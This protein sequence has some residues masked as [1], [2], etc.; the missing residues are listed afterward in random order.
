MTSSEARRT[1]ACIF[2]GALHLKLVAG[3]EIWTT[4]ILS[5]KKKDL[6]ISYMYIQ[7]ADFYEQT[8]ETIVFLHLF[9]IS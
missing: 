7:T 5:G 9:V 3:C 8:V 6:E 2:H 1:K 4:E